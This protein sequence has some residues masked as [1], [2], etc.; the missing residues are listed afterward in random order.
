MASQ[1]LLARNQPMD[2][3]VAI[4]ANRNRFLHL[5]PGEPFAKPL[6]GMTGPGNQVVFGRRLTHPPSTQSTGMSRIAI[7]ID[8]HLP[9]RFR[10]S[11]A[12]AVI[13][14]TPVRSEGSTSG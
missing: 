11:N 2:G 6:V 4:A 10:R 5:L 7:P 3:K 12:A 13:V 14:K 9:Y 8:F 1:F